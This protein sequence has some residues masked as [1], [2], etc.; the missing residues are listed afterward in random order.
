YLS[1]LAILLRGGQTRSFHRPLH[2]YINSLANN[3]LLVNRMQEL[4]S[5]D[6]RESA[7]QSRA[8]NLADREIPLFLALRAVKIGA[9]G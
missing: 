8:E 2:E 7:N 5:Y 4:D 6:E 1:P 9:A 3:G